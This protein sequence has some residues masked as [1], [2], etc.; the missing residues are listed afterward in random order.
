ME[1]YR[2]LL[3]KIVLAAAILSLQACGGGGDK[4][5]QPAAASASSNSSSLSPVSSS[6]AASSS[7]AAVINT[8]TIS[9]QLVADSLAGA[10]IEVTAG[11]QHF[12][13]V[14]DSQQK[15]SITLEVTETN[16]NAPIVISAQ[17]INSN[18]W[19]KLASLLPSVISAKKLAGSNGILD[20][21]EFIGVNLSPLS[22]AEYALAKAF[23]ND[24][25]TDAE[26]TTALLN[27]SAQQQLDSASVLTLLFTDIDFNLP[28]S[29]ATTLDFLLNDNT[30]NS[31]VNILKSRY[32]SNSNDLTESTASILSDNNQLKPS[33]DAFDGTYFIEG[34]DS[35]LVLYMK[36]EGTGMLHANSNPNSLNI[37]ASNTTT[38]KDIPFSWVKKGNKLQISFAA[39]IN[40]GKTNEIC[41]YSYQTNTYACKTFDIIL[42]SIT[43]MLISENDVS[44]L[45]SVTRD[46]S[47][48]SQD[49]SIEKILDVTYTKLNNASVFQAL[50]ASDLINKEWYTNNSSYVFNADLSVKQTN[51]LTGELKTL[52][53]KLENNL[54]LIDNGAIEIWPTYKHEA[55]FN[56]KEVRPAA[57]GKKLMVQRLPVTMTNSNWEGRWQV[58]TTDIYQNGFYDFTS[59]G[60]FRDG[61]DV[62][63][64]SAWSILTPTSSLALETGHY[65]WSSKRDVLAIVN[66]HYYFSLCGGHE[67]NA[68]SFCSL[69]VATIDKA[70]SGNDLW[71]GWSSAVFQDQYQATWNFVYDVL[72]IPSLDIPFLTGY[73]KV[74]NA[75]FYIPSKDTVIELLSASKTGIEICAHKAF[76]D[77]NPSQK[78]TLTRGLDIGVSYTTN[79]DKTRGGSIGKKFNNETGWSAYYTDS[80]VTIPNNQSVEFAF[81]PETGYKLAAVSGCNGAL[82]GDT[83]TVPARTSTCDIS[84]S[85]V[86]L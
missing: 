53:W 66:N 36:K 45:A 85:F 14:A 8:L 18:A 77:C 69:E 47:R 68:L 70:F 83:Y 17:G 1:K 56:F 46:I 22:T 27:V 3:G 7:T 78:F 16:K 84:I 51:L 59:D 10:T 5:T 13:A 42:N 76:A 34:D 29:A 73:R 72:A 54:L 24:I 55:G 31:Y 33:T 58:K 35:H 62:D 48:K 12:T 71:A 63:I 32:E 61:F 79:A 2:F 25:N 44:T 80:G 28:K 9:G 26:R 65:D 4:E 19:I 57:V 67:T 60:K 74:S 86:P 43:L 49:G 11:N 37:D 30:R 38:F 39:P 50:S 23:N 75:S 81:F 20:A 64:K 15:Y 21:S 52:P 6:S 82:V 41:G 40:Y